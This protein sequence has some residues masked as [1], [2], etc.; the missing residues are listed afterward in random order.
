MAEESNQ[1]CVD[2]LR[3]VARRMR[4]EEARGFE[5]RLMNDH[6]YSDAMAVCEQDLI[7]RFAAGTLGDSDRTS[8]KT[9]IESSP[10]RV[11]RV[12]MA[13]SLLASARHTAKH[14][15][16]VRFVL[17]IAAVIAGLAVVT[18]VAGR[19]FG[20]TPGSAQEEAT[21]HGVPA[22]QGNAANTNELSTSTNH[23]ILVIAE[24]V[25][26]EQHTQLLT[27]FRD[28][29]VTLQVL[30]PEDSPDGPYHLRMARTTDRTTVVDLPGLKPV[31][32]GDRLYLIANLHKGVLMPG[33]YEVSVIGTEDTFIS[34]IAVD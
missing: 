28:S 29:A 16:L 13:Q 24:R 33:T 31:F 23:V 6:A 22:G 25:R 14:R 12:R 30:L 26:G 32:A 4:E 19:H 21:L 17:P 10:G 3:Y 2:F 1:F 18:W 11:Q 8:L 27:P 20:R 34:R 5:E 15:T 7:D 9:W